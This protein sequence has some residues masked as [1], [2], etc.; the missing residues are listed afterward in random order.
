MRRLYQGIGLI[1]LLISLHVFPA[2]AGE[3]WNI[4]TE[5]LPPYNF[6]RGEM[7]HGI[8]A[9]ILLE[10]MNKNGISVERSD[11]RLLPWPRAYRMV[12][13]VPDSIL[14]SAGRTAEREKLF[15]WVGPITDLTIGLTALKERNIRLASLQDAEKY[16]IGT[17]RDG[18]PEQL[19]L[20]GGVGESSLDRIADP[21]LNIKKLQAGRIDLFA[22]N[23]PS[24][25]YLMIQ[26]GIDP[27]EYES[28]Y[29][30]KQVDLYY[31]FHRDTDDRLINA[32]NRTLQKMKQPDAAGS[33]EVDRIVAGYLNP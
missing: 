23:V 9:D 26:M 15:K 1:V 18:A 6:V 16:T 14:F 32:L 33:S 21:E 12:Q 13:D 25:R 24:T 31:A 27:V 7:V 30:L 3:K 19:L 29:T 5:E 22:F 2:V 8:C 28:V 11:I 20:K 17:I 4:M 10:I